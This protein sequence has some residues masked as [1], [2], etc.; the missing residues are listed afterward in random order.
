M[1]L[2]IPNHIKIQRFV[3]FSSILMPSLRT[4]CKTVY[5]ECW[6]KARRLLSFQTI[7]HNSPYKYSYDFKFS[8]KTGQCVAQTSKTSPS[9]YSCKARRSPSSWI[10]YSDSPRKTLYTC[11]FSYGLEH[12]FIQWYC[13]LRQS[14]TYHYRDRRRR[15]SVCVRVFSPRDIGWILQ[16]NSGTSIRR[17]PYPQRCDSLNYVDLSYRKNCS[18]SLFRQRAAESKPRNFDRE[19]QRA[20]RSIESNRELECAGARSTRASSCSSKS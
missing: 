14:S 5:I 6:Y 11:K 13:V 7:V 12:I 19:Q 8:Y 18:T 3:Q 9:R 10:L 16:S 1:L 2:H 4:Q 17:Y 20:E 15:F